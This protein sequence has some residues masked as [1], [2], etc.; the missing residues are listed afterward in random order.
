M[1]KKRKKKKACS[2]VGSEVDEV[3]GGLPS[4]CVKFLIAP[5]GATFWDSR[6]QAASNAEMWPAPFHS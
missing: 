1:L 2:V 3:S 6:S 5:A 4:H